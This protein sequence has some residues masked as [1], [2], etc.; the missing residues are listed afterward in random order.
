FFQGEGVFSFN[1]EFAALGIPTAVVN[2]WSVD[3]TSTYRL[4]ELF[5]KY[6]SQGQPAD[7]AL[8]QAK[9]EFLHNAS[10]DQRLPYY[11]AAP[12][13][14]GQATLLPKDPPSTFGRYLLLLP[15]ALLVIFVL[16]FIR[17]KKAV[18]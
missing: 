4:T 16:V 15:L 3:N 1:R 10:G 9:K 8:Q 13:L 14:T 5:Y 6:L 7:I 18:S 11:W 17:M 2:C 12:V